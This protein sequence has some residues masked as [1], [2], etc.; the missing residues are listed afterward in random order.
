MNVRGVYGGGGRAGKQ[1]QGFE[2]GGVGGFNAAMQRETQG[3][4]TR[5]IQYSAQ[6]SY[7]A[8]VS[9]SS[10]GLYKQRNHM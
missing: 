6:C 1:R 3:Y 4:S 9:K 2:M 7:L 5:N 10:I 8:K